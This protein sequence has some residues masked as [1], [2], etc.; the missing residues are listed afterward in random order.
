[1][2]KLLLSAAVLIAV[3]ASGHADAPVV[4]PDMLYGEWCH[5]SGGDSR[6]QIN[7]FSSV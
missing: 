1:M 4:M 6:A 2:K 5:I 3:S 7:K